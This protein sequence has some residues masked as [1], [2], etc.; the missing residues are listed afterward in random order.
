MA[1]TEAAVR[2]ARMG[3]LHALAVGAAVAGF[4]FVLLW[5]SEAAG[6]V[7][8]PPEFLE[9]LSDDASPFAVLLAGLPAAAALGAVCGASVAVFANLFRFLD[10]R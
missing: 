4:L 1:A 10:R 9:M 5:A 8:I 7:L 2:P 6:L 3:V